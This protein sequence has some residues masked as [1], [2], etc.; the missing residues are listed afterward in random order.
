MTEIER[1]ILEINPRDMISRIKKLRPKP[2]KIF[3]GFV[4]VKYFDYPDGRIRRKKDLLR[5]REITPKNA[6]PFT[7][8]VYK[9][10]KGVKHRCK[11]FDEMELV[12]PGV[13]QFKIVGEFLM[14][15]GLKQTLYYEKKRT[16]YEYG[17][18]KFEID[19]HPRIPAF[20]EIEAG[21]PRLI[22][23]IIKRLNLGN[24]EQTAESIAEFMERKY[25]KISLNG[26]VFSKRQKVWKER[27]D[28]PLPGIEKSLH[29]SIVLGDVQRT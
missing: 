28:A 23:G 8:L 21:S 27:F 17:K 18:I 13:R 11:Y 20:L 26:L 12:L 1:K 5:L 4:R 3:E 7:E 2:K 19:E 16:Q 9:T 6:T 10:Y 14:R 29:C 24:H 25:P 15:F 22:D